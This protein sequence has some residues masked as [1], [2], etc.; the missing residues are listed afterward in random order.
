MEVLLTASAIAER[1]RYV[2]EAP[3]GERYAIVAFIGARPLQWI[4]Q[5]AGLRVFC[6]PS[7]GGTHPDGIDA[8]VKEGAQV[9]FVEHLHSKVYHSARGTVLGSPNLSAN[10][11]GGVLTE[12]A[13]FLPPENFPIDA[14]L[15]KLARG[16]C[17]P[18][19]SEFAARLALLRIEHN[20]YRQRNPALDAPSQSTDIGNLI[21]VET[22]PA[23]SFGEWFHSPNRSDWQLGAWTHHSSIPDDVAEQ[24][25]DSTGTEAANWISDE[26]PDKYQLMLPTLECRFFQKSYRITKKGMRWWFPNVVRMTNNPAWADN[27]HIFLAQELVPAGCSVPFNID[28]PGFH[29]ALSN[30]VNELGE[31]SEHIIGAVTPKFIDTIARYYFEPA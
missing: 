11:L 9:A 10:A 23:Q 8:L 7:A 16:F 31:K 22:G 13:V 3:K 29:Q 30:A 24:Q 27:A 19:T 20:A 15:T 25:Q 18:G 1:V 6:W 12:T 21:E 5:P 4:A 26:R 17:G 28:E 2:L 14:Q